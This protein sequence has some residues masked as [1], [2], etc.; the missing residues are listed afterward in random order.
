MKIF[1]VISEPKRKADILFASSGSSFFSL[2]SIM[3]LEVMTNGWQDGEL[4]RVL[5]P[6]DSAST[7]RAISHDLKPGLISLCI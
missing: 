6:E 7:S 2:M 1:R 3:R 5:V 4:V